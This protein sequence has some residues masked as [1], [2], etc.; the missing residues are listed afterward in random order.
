MYAGGIADG[1]VLVTAYTDLVDLFE[2]AAA[3]GTTVHDLVGDDP[4]TFADDFLETYKDAQWVSKEKERLHRAF[5]DL[6]PTRSDT[7]GGAS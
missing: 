7:T 1:D 3:D 6:D 5:A 2:S 4:A